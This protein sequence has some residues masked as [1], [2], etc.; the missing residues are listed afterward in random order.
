MEWID[1]VWTLDMDFDV[2]CD[3]A[4]WYKDHIILLLTY[5]FLHHPLYRS[6]ALEWYFLSRGHEEERD[7][8]NSNQCFVRRRRW[9]RRLRRINPA[10]LEDRAARSLGAGAEVTLILKGECND[11]LGVSLR[12]DEEEKGVYLHRWYGEGGILQNAISEFKQQ[13]PSAV[14]H[15]ALGDIVVEINNVNLAGCSLKKCVELIRDEGESGL[16]SIRLRRAGRGGEIVSSPLTPVPTQ[17]DTRKSISDWMASRTG[18]GIHNKIIDSSNVVSNSEEEVDRAPIDDLDSESN[19]FASHADNATE[20]DD[21]GVTEGESVS[22]VLP[23]ALLSVEFPSMAQL[24]TVLSPKTNQVNIRE[25]GAVSD[26]SENSLSSLEDSEI[27]SVVNSDFFGFFPPYETRPDTPPLPVDELKAAMLLAH[28][29]L[30]RKTKHSR[31]VRFA[32][33]LEEV[34]YFQRDDIVGQTAIESDLEDD[35]FGDSEEMGAEDSDDNT[36]LR[37]APVPKDGPVLREGRTS[38]FV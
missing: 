1:E 22:L 33:E 2:G 11:N 19:T 35:E 14:F 30:V 28:A 26:S 6:Y 8:S 12:Y 36:P 17:V 4:G 29:P 3:T 38:A 23:S 34:Q 18:S 37:R 20:K 24:M 16:K 27:K 21:E 7:L 13:H 32:E 15:P 9:L 5:S 25:L 10:E 31:S